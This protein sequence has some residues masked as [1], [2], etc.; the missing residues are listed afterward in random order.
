VILQAADLEEILD[1]SGYTGVTPT[2]PA[3]L[4]AARR[5]VRGRGVLPVPVVQSHHA[6][7]EGEL[8]TE[9]EASADDQEWQPASVGSTTPAV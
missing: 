6:T 1:A 5:S 9:R 2:T 7:E 8:E 4:E 3:E